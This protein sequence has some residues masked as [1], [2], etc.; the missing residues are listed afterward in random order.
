MEGLERPRNPMSEAAGGL[1]RPRNPMSEASGGLG[2]PRTPQGEASE[3]LQY[4]V[5]MFAK[6]ASLRESKSG[7][8]KSQQ[9]WLRVRG[10]PLFH[11]GGGCDFHFFDGRKK[12][13]RS[14]CVTLQADIGF[15]RASK[16]N[17]ALFNWRRPRTGLGRLGSLQQSLKLEDDVACKPSERGLKFRVGAAR[18]NASAVQN[19]SP[20]NCPKKLKRCFKSRKKMIRKRGILSRQVMGQLGSDISTQMGG[21]IFT[22]WRREKLGG[23]C[24][25]KVKRLKA[26]RWLSLFQAMNWSWRPHWVLHRLLRQLSLQGRVDRKVEKDFSSTIGGNAEQATLRLTPWCF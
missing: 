15:Q 17:R 6:V 23:H 7:V 24:R 20:P 19:P 16:Q 5:H 4:R 18:L 10:P 21:H 13:L 12:V 1:G 22:V 2:R 14:P 9:F 3:A 25:R 8:E 26:T 11:N